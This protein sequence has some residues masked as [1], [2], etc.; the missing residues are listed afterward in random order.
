MP[1]RSVYT[2]S[3]CANFLSERTRLCLQGRW[4]KGT[5]RLKQTRFHLQNTPNNLRNRQTRTMKNMRLFLQNRLNDLQN[6]QTCAMK[7]MRLFLQNRLS[8][9]LNRLWRRWGCVYKTYWI[10]I[11]LNMLR[12]WKKCSCVYQTNWIIFWIGCEEGEAVF[13]KHIE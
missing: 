5:W 13:T 8:N 9:L 1:Q 6:R 3:A 10:I 7:N 11:W 12:L 4:N 2:V